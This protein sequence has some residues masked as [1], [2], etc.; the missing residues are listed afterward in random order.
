M[1]PDGEA[2]DVEDRLDRAATALR[3]ECRRTADE[4]EALGEFAERVREIEAERAV[5][6]G[7]AVAAVG[8]QTGRTDGLDAVREAYESTVMSVPHYAQEYDDGYLGSLQAEFSPDL[9]AAL[10][11][12]T[13]FN[14]RCKR[15]VLS[16]V[17]GSRS[18]RRSLLETLSTEAESLSAATDTLPSVAREVSEFAARSTA[19]APFGTLDA[20][21]ARLSV[22]EGKCETVADERQSTLFEQRRTTGLPSGAPDVPQYVYQDLPF[23]YPVMAAVADLTGAIEAVRDDLRWALARA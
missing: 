1:E 7:N 20:H 13:R 3:R 4:L 12:G 23:D 17:E 5:A 22:L 18:S 10:T 6:G 21:R 16:A 11:D 8:L 14:A 19:E 9:A 2:F 15:A